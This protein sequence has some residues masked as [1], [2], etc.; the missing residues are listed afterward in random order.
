MNTISITELF[1]QLKKDPR[2]IQSKGSKKTQIIN[3]VTKIL[4]I[5]TEED[6]G[7]ERVEVNVLYNLSKDMGFEFNRV[8]FAHVVESNWKVTRSDNG[9]GVNTLWLNLR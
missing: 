9:Y 3:V 8:Y 6:P 4:G 2:Y 7:K 5:V 1:D